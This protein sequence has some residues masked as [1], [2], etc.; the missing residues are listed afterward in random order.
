MAG[1]NDLIAFGFGSW[2]SVNKVPT[3]GLGIGEAAIA[4]TPDGLDYAA[5]DNRPHYLAAANR[6]HHAASD[7]R[8][9]YRVEEN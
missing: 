2:G 8:P 4:I 5:A 3:W 6:P 7:N 9:H 1:V